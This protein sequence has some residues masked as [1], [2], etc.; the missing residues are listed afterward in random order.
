MSFRWYNN[1][2][3]EFSEVGIWSWLGIMSVSVFCY[4]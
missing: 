2:K 3:I 4:L 1:V